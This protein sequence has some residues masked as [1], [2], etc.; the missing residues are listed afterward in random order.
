MN[1]KGCEMY[2]I[3]WKSKVTGRCGHGEWQADLIAVQSAIAIVEDEFSEIE[4]WIEESNHHP[5]QPSSHRS[6]QQQHTD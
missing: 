4:H 5:P 1:W 2:R 6:N 3:A